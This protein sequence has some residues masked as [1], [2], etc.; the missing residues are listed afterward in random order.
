[1]RCRARARGPLDREGT[2]Q[3]RVATAEAAINNTCH[4]TSR[5]GTPAPKPTW[6]T[7][8]RIA[9]RAL[10]YNS[11]YSSEDNFN[12]TSMVLP[13]ARRQTNKA[14]SCLQ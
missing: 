10:P 14:P 8:L 11:A 7:A 4:R 13:L 6:P 3:K 9:I 12:R 2:G 5:N 1:M